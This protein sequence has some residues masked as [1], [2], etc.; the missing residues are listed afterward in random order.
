MPNLQGGGPVELTLEDLLA[1]ARSFLKRPGR[2]MLG[3][4]GPPGAGKSTVTEHLGAALGADAVVV[5][6]DGFHLSNELLTEMGRRGRK[7]APDTFDVAGYVSLLRRIRDRDAHVYAPRFDRAIEQS[8]GS[9]QEVAATIP[10]VITEGNYL[11]TTSHGWSEVR[12][13][14]DEVWYIDVDTEVVRRRLVE[15][16]AGHGH[17]LDA[18]T[19]WVESVDLPNARFVSEARDRADLIARLPSSPPADGRVSTHIAHEET[20]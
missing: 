12:D 9:A 13:L 3:I 8:I 18:A 1:R 2:T 4:T 19:E 14:L 20:R 16:R 11:L 10:L 5:P 6:M 15:R 7:G 17:P